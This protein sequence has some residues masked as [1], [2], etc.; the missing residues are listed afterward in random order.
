[1][2]RDLFETSEQRILDGELTQYT[3]DEFVVWQIEMEFI[4]GH[5][6][7]SRIGRTRVHIAIVDEQKIDIVH[8]EAGRGRLQ[9]ENLFETAVH[10]DALVECF[11]GRLLANV[12]AI[13]QLLPLQNRMRVEEK[14]C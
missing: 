11:I 14:V 3:S 7:M 9:L 2:P 10:H 4:D 8:D 5:A 1:M 13:V 12:D 6:Q